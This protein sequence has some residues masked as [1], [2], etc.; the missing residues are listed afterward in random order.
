MEQSTKKFSKLAVCAFVLT[1][2]VSAFAGDGSLS[3]HQDTKVNGTLLKAGDYKVKWDDAGSVSILSG[4]K[5]VATAYGKVD[6][7]KEKSQRSAA[8]S[9]Q[10]GDAPKVIEL[11]FS[12]K[13]EILKLSDGGSAGTA[14]GA[15][16]AVSHDLQSCD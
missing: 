3:L 11:Q 1:F 7:A 5:V 12:G 8:V 2:A 10:D 14:S 16:R 6:W 15:K 9:V 13:K 4:K